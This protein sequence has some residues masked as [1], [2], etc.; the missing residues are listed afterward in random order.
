MKEGTIGSMQRKMVLFL[1]WMQK[2]SK[3]NFCVAVSSWIENLA[4]QISQ[5]NKVSVVKKKSANKTF[6]II[7]L[8]LCFWIGT[9]P[10]KPLNQ[11]L[12][13]VFIEAWGLSCV[14]KL[15]LL[16]RRLFV[17]FGTLPKNR[18]LISK[19]SSILSVF[20][21]KKRKVRF[22]IMGKRGFLFFGWH[23]LHH[24][25]IHQPRW[26]LL[27]T[28]RLWLAVGHV[29]LILLPDTQIFAI[30]LNFKRNTIAK[31]T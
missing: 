16:R 15:P 5:R 27:W 6:S 1:K 22:S 2:N 26:K 3:E 9:K 10:S 24:K 12:L 7:K 21:K 20:S 30:L 4:N 23:Y 19:L 17:R 8:V 28:N 25:R 18:V 31:E 29:F 13:H 11:L 14:R